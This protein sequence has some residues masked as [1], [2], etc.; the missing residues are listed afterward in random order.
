MQRTI[1]H[2][3]HLCAFQLEGIPVSA[4]ESLKENNSIACGNRIGIE[5]DLHASQ[6][7][8]R[9]RIENT[10]FHVL[11]M[12]R[13]IRVLGFVMLSEQCFDDSLRVWTNSESKKFI[14]KT[15]RMIAFEG[16][17]PPQGYSLIS[18]HTILHESNT[19]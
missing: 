4:W 1:P 17:S 3:G 15:P 18:V 8:V 11:S 9:P 19:S 13:F 2:D 10:A 6:E 5:F 16:G 7:L 14:T 12:H